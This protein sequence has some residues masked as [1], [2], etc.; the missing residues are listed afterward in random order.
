MTDTD[1]VSRAAALAREVHEGGTRKG[2]EIPYF[3]GH[4]EPV[5]RLVEESGGN[6]AQVARELG[7]YDS[8]LGLTGQGWW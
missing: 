8:S 2:T 7:I 4:L 6:I 1:L 3:D 5:A